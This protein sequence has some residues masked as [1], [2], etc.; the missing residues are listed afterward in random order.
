MAVKRFLIGS[1][2]VALFGAGV[3]FIQNFVTP[4]ARRLGAEDSPC[5]GDL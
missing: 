5:D 2:V 4:R 1:A 3:S